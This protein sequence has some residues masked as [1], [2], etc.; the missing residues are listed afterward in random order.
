MSGGEE[1]GLLIAL[2]NP[3]TKYF[4]PNI[5]AAEIIA[6][7]SSIVGLVNNYFLNCF[8]WLTLYLIDYKKETLNV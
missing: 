2:Y 8:S 1:K 6:G 7:L 3:F 4:W 5:I